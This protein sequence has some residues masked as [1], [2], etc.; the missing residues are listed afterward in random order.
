MAE[1]PPPSGFPILCGRCSTI[2]LSDLKRRKA[3]ATDRLIKLSDGDGLFLNVYPNGRRRWRFSYRFGGK[4]R[5]LAI[6]PYPEV[7]LLEAR[8][9][10]YAARR[11][12]RDGRD[13]CAIRKLEEAT[14]ARLQETTFEAFADLYLDRLEK[15]GRSA[16][17][18]KK[19]RWIVA[20]LAA[21]L[22]PMQVAE[23]MSGRQRQALARNE[24]IRRSG[25]S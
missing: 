21:D 1:N 24:S 12:L 16:A 9:K 14:V 17:T 23:C 18:L 15:A 13:P 5:D 4:Q 7:S 6:G 10:R 2:E 22:R 19:S 20:D 3:T 25:R 8:E 11:L